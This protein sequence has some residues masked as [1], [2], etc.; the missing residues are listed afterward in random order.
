MT[1]INE[2]DTDW[3]GMTSNK[4]TLVISKQLKTL[5]QVENY[6]DSVA[7]SEKQRRPSK[8]SIK[9]SA[10]DHCHSETYSRSGTLTVK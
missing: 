5:D 2:K 6:I 3:N 10:S 8:E 4:A 1:K 7:P 9:A